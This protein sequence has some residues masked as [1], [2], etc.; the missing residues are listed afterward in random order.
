MAAP[1]KPALT[2]A[3]GKEAW[4]FAPTLTSTTAPSLAELN[5]AAGL[6]ISCMLFGDQGGL[7][8][9]TDKV[10]LPR[11]LCETEQY[12]ANGSTT[13]SMADLTVQFDPQGA[14][15]SNGKKAWETLL[16]GTTGYLWRRQGGLATADLAVGQFIDIIPV[17]LG[18][19]VPT[20]TGTDADGVFAFTSPVSVTNKPTF[21][22]A[23]V[24]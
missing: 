15:A 2:T 7:D 12:Q 21:N 16:P 6:N 5:A 14:A 17:E 10:T 8:A 24:V 4:G 23:V 20:K 1:I 19:R 13:Y 9:S 22:V 3:Y 18:P 11:R